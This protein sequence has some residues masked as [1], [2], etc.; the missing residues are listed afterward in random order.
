MSVKTFIAAMTLKA[1]IIIICTAVAVIS[2]TAV[3]V[4]L[5]VS[6]EDAYRVLKV[7]EMTGSA[8]VERNGSGVLDAYV[9]MNLESGD[10]LT[11]GEGST[12]RVSLDS[13]KYVLLDSGTILELIA[14][15]TPADSRT[16]INL[17][18]GTILNEITNPL[19][20]NSSY[21]VATPK[22]TMAVRGTSYIVSVEEDDLGGFIIREDTFNGIVEV[23]LLDEMG[24]PRNNKAI[25]PADKGVTIR[26]ERNKMSGN[27]AEIDGRS[28]FVF[29]DENGF[30]SEL[31][32]GQDPLRDI[33]YGMISATVRNSAL[34]SNDESLMILDEKIV[35]KLRGLSAGAAKT[36]VTT[37]A[38]VSE[39]VPETE[40]TPSVTSVPETSLSTEENTQTAAPADTSYETAPAESPAV[41]ETASATEA[42]SSE[43]NS[44]TQAAETSAEES[45]SEK[46]ESS[47]TSADTTAE[48]S[49]T[50]KTETDVTTVPETFT[51]ASTISYTV[52]TGTS[53]IVTSSTGTST[54][55][56]SATE[57]SVSETSATEPSE[58]LYI[59]NFICDGK[60]IYSEEVKSGETV[61][62]IPD[63]PEKTGYT[64]KWMSSGKEFTSETK[65]NSNMTV[66]ALYTIKSYTITLTSSEDPT[67]SK[68]ITADY[69]T[70]LSDVLPDVPEVTGYTG[71]WKIGGTVL[72][73]GG[74]TV[75]SDLDIKAVYTINTYTVTFKAE[76]SADVTRT[77]DHGTTIASIPEI[78][79][80][81]GYTAK[82]V[83][84]GKEFTSET[85]I[86]SDMTVTAEYTI[87]SYKITLTSEAD[88][89]YSKT[90]TADYG[91][92]LS[93]VLPDVPE[94]TGYTGVWKIGGTVL[95]SGGITV[96]S[97]LDIKAVYTINTYTVT[98]K[99]E[100]SADVT[101][102]A[103]HGTTIAS[104]P[105]IPEKTGYTAKWVSGGKEFTSETV[106]TSD[107][108][109]T[110]E[111]TII[112]YSITLTSSKDPS[113][114][115]TVS[116]DYG[117][118]LKDALPAVPEVKGYTGVWKIGGTADVSDSYKVTE[119]IAVEAVYT[120]NTYTVKF[121]A[122]SDTPYSSSVPADYGTL[123]SDILPK[124]P[125]KTG[126]DGVWTVDGKEID[127]D[128]VIEDDTNVIAKYTPHIYTV[129]F[130]T[131]DGSLY[132]TRKVE[133]NTTVTDIPDYQKDGF[134]IKWMYNG[135][136]FSSEVVITENIDVIADEIEAVKLTFNFVTKEPEVYIIPK[137]TSLQDNGYE[138]PEADARK[139]YRGRWNGYI[140]VDY[141]PEKDSSF[142]VIEETIGYSIFF[143]D[144]DGTTSLKDNILIYSEKPLESAPLVN[145]FSAD[146]WVA[147]NFSGGSESMTVGQNDTVAAIVDGL[148]LEQ[149]DDAIKIV[150]V[151]KDRTL[152]WY[153][154]NGTKNT[155]PVMKGDNV[156][157]KLES[158]YT[159]PTGYFWAGSDKETPIAEDMIVTEDNTVVY[160]APKKYTITLSCEIDDSY[161]KTITAA[162][163]SKLVDVLPEAPKITGYKTGVWKIGGMTEITAA[164]T[165]TGDMSIQAVYGV[166]ISY[167]VEFYAS[168]G[169]THLANKYLTFQ[170]QISSWGNIVC[171]DKKIAAPDYWIV[172]S[173][174]GSSSRQVGPY[175]D[176]ASLVEEFGFDENSTIKIVAAP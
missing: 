164:D 55:V 93:D 126:H 6:K 15:G 24:N 69:G 25:V 9:G 48:N 5:A 123:L 77:A 99:A 36:D 49:D 95:V 168:D 103:N 40:V 142:D 148:G 10:T 138:L 82:W 73:S 80:K 155:S 136:E 21:E 8:A 112:S 76:G 94:V 60:V 32:E 92:L 161:S 42:V 91:T 30:I 151:M 144:T 44:D 163:G 2:A 149:S 97:D 4:G 67:Y 37:E 160:A 102:K 128:F 38:A 156:L 131:A 132:D 26:T 12:L 122:N 137:G 125:E 50:Q 61:S 135:S 100:G 107:M 35:A 172:Y 89:S 118:L 74:I 71:V 52:Q 90:I 27:P 117:T 171:N 57:T 45:V 81:T 169:T 147:Y 72:V 19:S 104:I 63:I 173:K 146:S 53:S 34:R 98:F 33:I 43:V 20:A 23:I 101:R 22:A 78:P 62:N 105:K 133:Y 115:K 119:D 174:D 13:D 121:T 39:T 111:Y 108:T 56:T 110:A 129:K 134:I 58:E 96:T 87:I 130:L 153:D 75:T 59:V 139:Y 16:T 176:I 70:L 88:A 28:R 11:V 116:A 141:K 124:M 158:L 170:D 140:T 54:T 68:T 175:E 114:S 47:A 79:E 167:L 113:Y 150:A 65:V 106:I 41:S 145:G 166:P 152:T 86:T 7:F 1:K 29:E 157:K 162:F 3:A 120:I 46:S 18:Q 83:S 51:N 17:K 109:V 127:V 154:E 85:V 31:G 66:A 159:L 64:A 84:G 143:Y 14:S 165:V